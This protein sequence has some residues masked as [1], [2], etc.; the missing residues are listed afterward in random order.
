LHHDSAE[1]GDTSSAFSFV[2][3]GPFGTY[4]LAGLALGL[5]CYA[6]LNFIRAGF[7]KFKY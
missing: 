6:V 2:R 3:N 7:E 4:M 5:I 1:A